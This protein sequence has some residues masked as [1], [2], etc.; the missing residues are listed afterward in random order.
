MNYTIDKSNL[1]NNILSLNVG[2][3]LNYFVEVSK[4]LENSDV[5]TFNFI[6]SPVD[7]LPDYILILSREIFESGILEKND[8]K[9]IFLLIEDDNIEQLNKK[10]EDFIDI[11]KDSWNFEIEHEP[12]TKIEGGYSYI[13]NNTNLIYITKK[14]KEIILDDKKDVNLMKFCPN[15][16]LENNN[17]KFCPNCGTNLKQA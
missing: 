2:E 7:I 9:K 16:G 13:N 10:T 11:I 3:N 14:E 17:Y 5:W 4:S 8:I 15:C 6:K 1:Q 12:E